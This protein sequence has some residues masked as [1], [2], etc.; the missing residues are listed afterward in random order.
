MKPTCFQR[1]EILIATVLNHEEDNGECYE[2]IRG[3]N[4]G[5]FHFESVQGRIHFQG[6]RK[7]L[8]FSELKVYRNLTCQELF[9]LH[10]KQKEIICVFSSCTY[11]ETNFDL[12][13]DKNNFSSSHFNKFD[14]YFQEG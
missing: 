8:G 14:T 10:F 11:S 1:K 13:L 7:Y 6:E 4:I 3:S 2:K 12:T 5:L 9:E